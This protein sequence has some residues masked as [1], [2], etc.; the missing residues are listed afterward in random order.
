MRIWASAC[1]TKRLLHSVA[2]ASMW[3]WTTM[4]SSSLMILHF[5][6]ESLMSLSPCS[7][8]SLPSEDHCALEVRP[9]LLLMYA[10]E[11]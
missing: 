7:S 4:H 10:L 6:T 5:D 2:L 9:M 1:S 11:W 8:F 3:A